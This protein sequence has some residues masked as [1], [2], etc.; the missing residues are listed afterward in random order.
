METFVAFFSAKQPELYSF[1]NHYSP[2]SPT[3]E[4]TALV[5]CFS[6]SVKYLILQPLNLKP[7]LQER[8]IKSGTLLPSIM[9]HK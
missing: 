2:P 9:P 7:Y 1:Q 3:L 8:L 4:P 6:L 5:L